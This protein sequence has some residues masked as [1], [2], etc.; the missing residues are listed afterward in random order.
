MLSYIEVWYL[1]FKTNIKI[2]NNVCVC[3]GMVN[4]SFICNMLFISKALRKKVIVKDDSKLISPLNSMTWVSA[5]STSKV[6]YRG[7][8]ILKNYGA[9]LSAIGLKLWKI[10]CV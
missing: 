3:S 1:D 7:T 2:Y 8:I 9:R 6:N 10:L 4:Y 5:W